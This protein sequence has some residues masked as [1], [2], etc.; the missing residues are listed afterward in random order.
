MIAVNLAHILFS[1]PLLMY[2][3]HQ[4]PE[5]MWIY[6]LLLGLG[7]FL[8]GFFIWECFEHLPLSQRHVFFL[9]HAIVFGGLLIYVGV[10]GRDGTPNVMFSLLLAIG[11]AAFG[12]HLVRFSD[13]M[14]MKNTR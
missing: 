8:V 13:T 4:K 5:N 10:K 11:I 9:L 14:F 2:V 3:G 12:Y 6:R 7:I 1:G